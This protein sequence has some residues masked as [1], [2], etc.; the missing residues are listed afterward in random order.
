MTKATIC[1]HLFCLLK[2]LKPIAS[3]FY[4]RFTIKSDIQTLGNT[5][6]TIGA[7]LRAITQ[8]RKNMT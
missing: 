1:W 2:D 3:M 7:E 4:H 6:K 8:P 5:W